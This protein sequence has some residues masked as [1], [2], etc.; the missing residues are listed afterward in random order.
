M[1]EIVN[2]GELRSIRR[3]HATSVV[4]VHHGPRPPHT[5]YAGESPEQN[6]SEEVYFVHQEGN[7]VLG[8]L[9]KYTVNTG[10]YG[11]STVV[12]F[13]PFREVKHTVTPNYNQRRKETER[14]TVTPRLTA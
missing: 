5:S 12:P 10:V 8:S 11:A 14:L 13:L 4:R 3:W 6:T 1:H 9:Q 2:F 7:L